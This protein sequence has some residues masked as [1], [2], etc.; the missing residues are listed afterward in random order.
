MILIIFHKL[1]PIHRKNKKVKVLDIKLLPI[2]KQIYVLR[3]D[4]GLFVKRVQKLLTGGLRLISD[5]KIY[6]SLDL[7]KVELH[8]DNFVEI[9]G[10]V[11]YL[12][13]DLPD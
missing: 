12:G 9:I 6:D 4:D 1:L 8:Q 3:I 11:V 5:N 13:Y 10:Q 7:S 2:L